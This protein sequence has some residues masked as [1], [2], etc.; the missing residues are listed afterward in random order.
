M[1]SKF[2]TTGFVLDLW[3]YRYGL[4]DK[5]TIVWRCITEHCTKQDGI[6]DKIKQLIRGYLAMAGRNPRKK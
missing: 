5:H 3:E 1:F 4:I 6:V 2:D